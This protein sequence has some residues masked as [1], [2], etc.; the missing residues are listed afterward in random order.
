MSIRHFNRVIQTLTGDIVTGVDVSVY[1]AGTALL[2]DL[3]SDVVGVLP[4]ANP[5]FNNATFGTVDFYV[6]E[7]TYDLNFTKDGY[8]FE[9]LANWTIGAPLLR[10]IVMVQ[11]IPGA[12][13]LLATDAIPAGARVSGVFVTNTVAFGSSRGLTGYSVGD[14]TTV[15]RW[16]VNT[17]LQ[18]VVTNQADFHSGDLPIYPTAAAVVLSG[19][20]GLFDA[21]GTAQI[22]VVYSIGAAL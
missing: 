11:A 19:V 13:L 12:S 2:A 6:E 4:K 10:H 18:G 9:Q 22:E 16:G 20:N 5:F 15:D 14:G 7:G 21:N 1:V 8:I 17:L 3:F